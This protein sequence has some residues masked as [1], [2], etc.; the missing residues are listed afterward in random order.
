LDQAGWLASPRDPAAL[1]LHLI[2]AL[3][4][5][6]LRLRHATALLD[7]MHRHYTQD[8]MVTTTMA[9]YDRL[10]SVRVTTRRA[11]GVATIVRD[12][13]SRELIDQLVRRDVRL[14][15]RQP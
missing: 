14:R 9:Q 12:L 8:H 6:A 2:D 13:T 4:S 11:D 7:R 3:R 1:A 15:Y 10:L 5:P